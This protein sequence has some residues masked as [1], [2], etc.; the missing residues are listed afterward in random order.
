MNT[1]FAKYENLFLLFLALV[2]ICIYANTIGSPFIFDSRKNIGSNPHI[3]ISKITPEGLANAA[4]KSPSWQRPLPNISFALNYYLHGTNVV[5]F[6]VVNILIHIS[7]AFLLYFFVKSTFCTPALR[8]RYSNYLW[9]SFF[10]AALWLVHPLQTQSVSY[11]VQRMNSMAAMFYILSMLLYAR[12]RLSRQH[13]NKWWLFA[14]CVLAGVLALASKQIAATLPFFIFA[15]EWYFFQDMGIKWLKR[16]IPLLIGCLVLA[17]VIG[18]ALWGD[19]LLD[20]MIQG[21][22]IRDFTPAQRLLTEPRVVIFYLGQLLWPHPARLNLDHDFSISHS[23][24]DPMTTFFAILV[25]A[26]LIGVAV[27]TA[28]KQRLLSFCI[29]WYFGNLVIESSIIPL[30]I[31]FEH[32]VY[33]PS[34]MFSLVLVLFV[35]RWVKPMWLQTGLLC[36]MIAVGSFWTYERNA[37][38]SDRITF[39]QD[40][41]NK[42]PG[43]A[44]THN[45][46]GVALADQGYHNEAIKKYREALQIDPL[47]PDPIANIGLSLARQ[48]K[49]EESIAQFLKA[50][51]IDP[52]NHQILSNLGASLIL[53]E[54]YPE[55]VQRLSEALALD[56]Y[57]AQAHNNLGVAFQFQ[58]RV[59][60]AIYHFSRA[61]QLDPEYLNAYNNLGIILANQGRFEE[62][63][64]QFSTALKINPGYKSARLNLE[65]SIKHQKI[66]RSPQQIAP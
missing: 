41:A 36:A 30:E 62:A 8:S 19:K 46:L 15:Y 38:Y 22:G 66:D 13:R 40:S 43:K 9:I 14:G 12:F 23:L 60:E 45:N 21:Y 25:I 47:Y 57:Q 32:R 48:G 63:I 51:E 34:M 61:V 29:V 56:S 5:G 16:Q 50:L 44:R 49:I 17:T 2:V 35:H 10:T 31:I 24:L 33:L 65:K 52:K 3:R 54:R 18:S 11:V 1:L 53:L 42:S 28:K 37:V 55:A 7:T 26:A 20:W 6:R 27:V 4:F 59:E 64:A 58:G 39:W